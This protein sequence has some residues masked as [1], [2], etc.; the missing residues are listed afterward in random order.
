MNSSDPLVLAG[1]ATIVFL[2]S[3]LGFVAL[4]RAADRH[5]RGA[6]RFR[7]QTLQGVWRRFAREGRGVR[8][9]RLQSRTVGETLFWSALES[10]ALELKRSEMKRLSEVL[11]R[12]GHVRA[13]RRALR[14]ESPWRRE[15]AARRLGFVHCG[16]SRRALRRAMEQ[17]PESV[18]VR[19]AFS[20]ARQRDGWALE[21][22]LDHPA[23]FTSR[24][25][26]A[27]TALLRAFGTAATPILAR[28]LESGV[29]DRQLERNV[30]ERL[31]AARHLPSAPIIRMRAASE[32]LELRI[33]A[34]RALSR[35]DPA[36]HL[37]ALVGAL[38]DPAWEV[39]A[40]AARALGI[41][42][43]SD[44]VPMLAGT[45]GDRAWWVR[46]HSAYALAKLGAEGHAALRGEAI[47]SPDRYAREMAREAVEQTSPGLGRPYVLKPLPSAP[48]ARPHDTT[49]VPVS[50]SPQP[51]APMGSAQ[52]M[53]EPMEPNAR[54]Q[55][56]PAEGSPDV[57]TPTDTKASKSKRPT[58]ARTPAEITA[59]LRA[60]ARRKRSA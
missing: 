49:P 31:G 5:R 40:Q 54:E 58:P 4:G 15:L 44:A 32:D 29:H 6:V 23:Y 26:R 41:S 59:A 28:R 24:P 19:A 18:A 22:I 45:L 2:A 50:A 25:P 47:S 35:L 55:D 11:A 3:V 9:V 56:A 21:W 20:L 46:H 30:I 52:S 27:R 42:G 48:E 37:D 39:R 33:S 17:G 10:L 13:E 57:V 14:D 43:V 60:A 38:S 53:D 16:D 36:A 34:V 51:A 1:V 8:A 7:V 12:S